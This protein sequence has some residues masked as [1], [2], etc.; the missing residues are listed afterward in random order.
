LPVQFLFAN[1]CC[2][3]QQGGNPGNYADREVSEKRHQRVVEVGMGD[4]G[5]I[6]TR[7]PGIP[8]ESQ[9]SDEY[10]QNDRNLDHAFLL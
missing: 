8:E 10:N 1:S 9:A 7:Q 3:K 2:G 4:P 6:K 5:K